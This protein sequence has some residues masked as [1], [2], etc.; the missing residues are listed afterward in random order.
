MKNTKTTG[1]IICFFIAFLFFLLPVSYAK[2]IKLNYS[3]FAPNTEP[4]YKVVQYFM[5]E[6]ETR[7]DGRVK[8]SYYPGGSLV[9]AGQAYDAVLKG[10]SDID[11]PVLAYTPARFPISFAWNLPLGIKSS[12]AGTQMM[13]ESFLKFQPKEFDGV[14]VFHIWSSPPCHLQV[15]EKYGSL[16]DIAGKKIRSTGISAEF[17]RA[18]GGT[19]VSMPQGGTYEA[20]QKG[21]VSGTLSSSNTLIVFRLG[22][23]LN[24]E[25]QISAFVVPFAFIMN[26][27]KWDNLPTDIQQIFEDVSSECIGLETKYWDEACAAGVE[28]G[29]QQGMQFYDLSPEMDSEIRAVQPILYRDY[30]DGLEKNGLREEG[31]AFLDYLISFSESEKNQ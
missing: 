31:Q 26:Q 29:K 17:V 27:K 7:T 30:L 10:I 16:K 11:F 22:E 2:T 13:N 28:F 14:K 5:K 3:W 15:K 6:V 25:Y 19:P 20:L 4:H 1:L 21:V 12:A 8:I 23:L 24:Y 18:L 9:S